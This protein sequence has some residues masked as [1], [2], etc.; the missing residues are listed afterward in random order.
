MFE[1]FLYAF[2]SVLVISL[3][4]L[5]GIFFL[6]IKSEKLEKF[7]IYMIAF[8][9]GTLLGDVF[10]HLIPE[11]VE[12]NNS[13]DIFLAFWL[14]AGIVFSFV[15][16]KI[17]RWRHC[18]HVTSNKHKHHLSKMNLIGDLFHNFI[19]G[20]IVCASYFVSIPLGIATTI[21]VIFHE[22][23][24]EIGD[25][26]VLVYSGYS[27]KKALLANFFISLS[28]FIG[29]FIALIFVNYQDNLIL[30]FLPFAAGNFIY[31]ACSDLIPELHNH[32]QS[33]SSECCYLC[34]HVSVSGSWFQLIFFLLG[35][36]IMFLLKIFG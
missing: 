1:S 2:V 19:D 35:I 22:I 18:H 24:Q 36:A 27:K 4:S 8:S 23:P 14:L 33:H 21:A 5:I 32:K 6:S 30:Y 26:G 31:I 10:I 28:A 9:A 25:F 12:I 13:F 20:I 29:L 7:L 3:I 15:V 34:E 11:S 17:I 16:E